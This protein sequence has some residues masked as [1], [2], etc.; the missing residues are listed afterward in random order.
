MTRPENDLNAIFELSHIY[1]DVFVRDF[2]TDYPAPEGLNRTHL[3]T[4]LYIFFSNNPKM[5][6]ISGKM[7]LEKGSFTP[8]AQKL[9]ALGYITKTKTDK[10]RRKSILNL[11]EKGKNLTM[12]YYAAHE[13]YILE[14]LSALGDERGR[15]IELLK[16]LLELTK[17]MQ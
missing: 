17:K 11:T 5:S 4:M 13:K 10:D 12:E 6:E 1:R 9:L 2:I 16:E 8:V 14:K 7:G 3:R 15:Y